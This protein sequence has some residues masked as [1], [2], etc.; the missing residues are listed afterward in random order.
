MLSNVTFHRFKQFRDQSFRIRPDGI[1]LIAGGNNSGKSSLL[2]GLAVWQFCKTA[3]EMEKGATAFEAG[4]VMQGLGL[5]DDEF[6]PI[7]VPSLNHLWTNL[8]SRKEE[9]PDG[10]TLKIRCDWISEDGDRC[11]E[12]GLALA[13]DRL[14]IKTTNSNLGPRDHIPNIAYRKNQTGLQSVPIELALRVRFQGFDQPIVQTA[15]IWQAL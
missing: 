3:L 4:G 10:Y 7:N 13:N 15:S 14:F 11:L 6:S 12:F 9:E 5:G 1:T 2:H 8:K